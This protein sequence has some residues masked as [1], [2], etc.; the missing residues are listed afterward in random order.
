MTTFSFGKVQKKYGKIYLVKSIK[1]HPS[2][3]FDQKYPKS[4]IEFLNVSVYKDE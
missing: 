2:I 1:K 3:K 4:K